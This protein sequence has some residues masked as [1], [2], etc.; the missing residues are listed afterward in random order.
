MNSIIN[1]LIS[2]YLIK[3]E[4]YYYI[5]IYNRQIIENLF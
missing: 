4:I 3:K 5:T 2:Y 1:K